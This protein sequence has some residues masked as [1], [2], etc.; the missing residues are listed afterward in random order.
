MDDRLTSKI[1]GAGAT[2]GL[3]FGALLLIAPSRFLSIMGLDAGSTASLL[4]QVLGAQLVGFN[5]AT[6]MAFR[7]RRTQ[8]PFVRGHVLA[9]LIAGVLSALALTRIDAAAIAWGVPVLFL[10]FGVGLAYAM[11]RPPTL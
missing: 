11:L 10:L 6:A 7:D 5:L 2:V 1:L 8:A 3:M 4:A 9:D